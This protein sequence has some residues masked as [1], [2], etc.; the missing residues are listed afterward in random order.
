MNSRWKTRA[1]HQRPKLEPYGDSLF[2]VAKTAILTE[3]DIVFGETHLFAGKN[4]LV[5]LRHGASKGY[6]TV[7]ARCENNPQRLALGTGYALYALLDDIVDNY[8]VVVS[9]L[10]NQFNQIEA[11]IFDDR[12]SRDKL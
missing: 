5:T 10:R 8:L 6:S 11:D 7:R 2:I 9:E 4:F 12:I 1:A 3:T